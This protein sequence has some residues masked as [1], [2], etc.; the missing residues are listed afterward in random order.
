MA[1]MTACL[2]TPA[3]STP[4]SSPAKIW[5]VKSLLSDKHLFV[6]PP[7]QYYIT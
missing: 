7:Q 3:E 2:I 5:F 6:S 1:H 4:E